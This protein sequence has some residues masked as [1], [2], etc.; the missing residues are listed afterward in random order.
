MSSRIEGGVGLSASWGELAAGSISHEGLPSLHGRSVLVST[1]ERLASAAALIQLDG[2]ARRIV[3]C[4][5]GLSA[6][7]LSFVASTAEA[8]T[9]VTDIAEAGDAALD[10]DQQASG[11]LRPQF[12]RLVLHPCPPSGVASLPAQTFTEWI[13]LTSGTTGR[14]KLVQH[15]LRSLTG[16]VDCSTAAP[17]S[18]VWSTFYD[19]LRYGGLQIFLRAALTGTPLVV[20][21]SS[22][23]LDDFLRRAGAARVTHISGTPSHWR[24]ALL[25]PA[26]DCLAPEYVRLSGEIADQ[27]I[28]N[29]LKSQYPEARVSHAFASTEAGVAFAV[30]DGCMGF[31]ERVLT[32]TPK[33]EMKVEEDTLRVRSG[34]TA[35]GYLASGDAG[36]GDGAGVPELRDGDGFVDTGDAVE[37]RAGRYYFV[38]R[39]D[40]AINVGGLKV[41][42]EEIEMVLNRHTQ[43][44]MSLVRAKKSAIMGTLVV[45][46]VVLTAE[47]NGDNPQALQ[48]DVLQFCRG[49][50][51]PYKVPA[52]INIVPRLAIAETGKLVRQN[53]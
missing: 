48:R 13:L 20:P 27:A 17:Q 14:P 4:P 8:D 34:R 22:E 35:S 6:E 16:A 39:R 52:V 40:G 10:P 23:P 38:G 5:A 9:L 30:N 29:Q 41:H 2:L 19:I 44:S 15:T 7:T 46:D 28:L 25:S 43:V 12:E 18:M 49:Q 42:P 33:V 11:G 36:G 26:A 32:D 31:A 37:L 53:A 50:L 47:S 24:R 3:L 1:V 45:A 21:G 51:A